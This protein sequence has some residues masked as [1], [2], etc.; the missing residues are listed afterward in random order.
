MAS[1]S[2]GSRWHLQQ[3]DCV[4]QRWRTREKGGDEGPHVCTWQQGGDGETYPDPPTLGTVGSWHRWAAVPS[5]GL[6]EVTQCGRW[7]RGCG[8]QT[9]AVARCG[10]RVQLEAPMMG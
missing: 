2:P 1:S 5:L 9:K 6:A 7:A 3:K 4:S 10:G 8:W